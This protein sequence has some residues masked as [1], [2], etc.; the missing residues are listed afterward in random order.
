MPSRASKAVLMVDSRADKDIETSLARGMTWALCR[1]LAKESQGAIRGPDAA[2][3]VALR[4]AVRCRAGAATSSGA[5]Y[6]PGS[7][8][9]HGECRTASGTRYRAAPSPS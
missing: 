5:W 8:E 9:R 7:A 3:R 6:G 4:E 2:Q 1:N